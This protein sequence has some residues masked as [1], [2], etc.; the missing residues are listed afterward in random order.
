M[1]ASQAQINANRLNGQKSTGPRTEEG[2]AKSS[3]NAMRH[4]LRAQELQMDKD[5]A[6]DSEEFI[7]EMQECFKPVGLHERNLVARITAQAWRL[8]RVVSVETGT[9]NDTLKNYPSRTLA[10]VF[11]GDPNLLLYGRYEAAIEGA[12]HRNIRELRSAQRYRLDEKEK[13]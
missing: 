12:M 11:G 6:E 2:K 9:V 1:S 7:R 13:A 4:G 5:V 3:Q 8:R 10:Q